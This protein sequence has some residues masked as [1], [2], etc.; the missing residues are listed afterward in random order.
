[1]ARAFTSLRN[2]RVFEQQHC[3]QEYSTTVELKSEMGRILAIQLEELVP[4]QQKLLGAIRFFKLN[5][6]RARNPWTG[7]VR[8]LR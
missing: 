3:G 6:V 5:S 1:M 8:A 2:F 4:K 7:D